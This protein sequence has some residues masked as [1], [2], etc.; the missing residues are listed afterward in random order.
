MQEQSNRKEGSG[1]E[2]EIAEL[3]RYLQEKSLDIDSYLSEE[4]WQQ[5]VKEHAAGAAASTTSDNYPDVYE[6]T[7]RRSRRRQQL[8][9]GIG[10]LVVLLLLAGLLWIALRPQPAA[11][12]P[13]VM[14]HVHENT[15][16]QMQKIGL[17][18]GSSLVLYPGSSISFATDYNKQRRDLQLTGK[19]VFEV[20]PKR[21][22]PFTVYCRSIA[23]TALGTRFMVNGLDADPWVHLYQG[24]VL[25]QPIS[26]NSVQRILAV[27]E[28]IAYQEKEHVFKLLNAQ[29]T[30]AAADPSGPS[31][32]P[33]SG[34]NN[35]L[36]ATAP[37]VPGKTDSVSV[38]GQTYI[39]FQNQQLSTIFDQLAERYHVEIRYPTDLSISTNVLLSV[40]AGQPIE[41]ILDNLCGANGM[42][43]KRVDSTTFTITK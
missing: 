10:G 24:K 18:D 33:R 23:T 40:N 39:N 31:P 27:G 35:T 12:A 6:A 41:K 30:A 2:K 13:A 25:V 3:A 20:S 8:F 37:A 28:T 1:R 43:V 34:E 32:T 11:N 7:I 5:Y 29:G 15:S 9:K 42:K 22:V 21:G 4:E 16:T 36:P 38:N 19:A 26:D 14:A 17:P